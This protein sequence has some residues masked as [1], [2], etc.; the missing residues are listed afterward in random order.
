MK[1]HF[2]FILPIIILVFTSNLIGQT[3][4][5][6]S[7]ESKLLKDRDDSTYYKGEILGQNK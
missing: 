5:E 4:V 2:K 7:E 6:G 3:I 1:I